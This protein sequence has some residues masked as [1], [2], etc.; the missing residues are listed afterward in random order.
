MIYY[1]F[2][3]D[4]LAKAVRGKSKQMQIKYHCSDPIMTSH[5]ALSYAVCID[6]DSLPLS[7]P[8]ALKLIQNRTF[9]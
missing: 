6:K 4:R 2:E 5:V 8:D 9:D 3:N 7:M 1:T